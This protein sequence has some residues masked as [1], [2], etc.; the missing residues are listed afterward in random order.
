MVYAWEGCYSVVAEY[1][2]AGAGDGSA[3][4]APVDVDVC[5]VEADSVDADCG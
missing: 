5:L 3:K 2:T 4:G 1:V